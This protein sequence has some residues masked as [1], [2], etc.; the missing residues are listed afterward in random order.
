[1]SRPVSIVVSFDERIAV[2]DGRFRLQKELSA[3]GSGFPLY[4]GA[5]TFL[6]SGPDAPFVAV[7]R[8]RGGWHSSILYVYAADGTPIYKEFLAGDVPS[9]MPY[10]AADGRMAFLL[11]G[12]GKVFLY[13]FERGG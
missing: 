1:V 6:G 5:A 8:G 11:G 7:Y 3:A 12:R 9:V 13:S 2:Y 4:V 10:D